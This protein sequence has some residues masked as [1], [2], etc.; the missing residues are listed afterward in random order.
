MYVFGV[1]RN[2]NLS[3][4]NFYCLLTI[5]AKVQSMDRKKTF[6]FVFGDVNTYHEEWLENSTTTLHG[7]AARSFASSGGDQMVTE[8]TQI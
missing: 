1:Y 6:L 3:N 8:P 4:N 2:S 7:R 5:M